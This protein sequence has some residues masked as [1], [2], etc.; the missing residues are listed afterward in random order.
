[1]PGHLIL[2]TSPVALL[3]APYIH[4]PKMCY[5]HICVIL[6]STEKNENENKD[7]MLDI[8][9]LGNVVGRGVQV[10]DC[11]EEF[12]LQ[13]FFFSLKFGVGGTF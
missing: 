3:P 10:R 8:L 9:D 7:Y 12:C 11:E 5:T 13:I 6:V 2:V 4:T 1:M